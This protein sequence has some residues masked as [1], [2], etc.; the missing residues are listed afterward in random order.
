MMKLRGAREGAGRIVREL[1]ARTIDGRQARG[2]LMDFG[3]ESPFLEMGPVE[4]WLDPETDLPM[5]ISYEW[6]KERYKYRDIYRMTDIRWNIDFPPERFATIAPAGLIN[7]TPPTDQSEINEM[8]AA[9]RLYAELSGGKYP[10][11]RT[12]Y[13]GSKSN[14]SDAPDVFD[15]EALREEMLRLANSSESQATEDSEGMNRKRE[16]IDAVS[17]GLERLSHVLLNHHRSGFFG[18]EVGMQE[19]DKVLLWWAAGTQAESGGG[20]RYRVFYGDLRTEI[21]PREKWFEVMPPEFKD[22]LD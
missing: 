9:L 19:K 15:Q 13:P 20:D 3:G 4:V 17:A 11:V 14:E 5:E 6:T 12:A 16:Q 22:L 7:A 8:L 1:G 2:Y 21:V 10:H 18:D